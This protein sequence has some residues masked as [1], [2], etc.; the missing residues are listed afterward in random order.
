M[1]HKELIERLRSKGQWVRSPVG[2]P[3]P[4]PME[5][6]VPDEDC[7]AAAKALAELDKGA[8]SI[9]NYEE[10]LK[11]TRR[12]T[13]ELDVAMHGEDGAAQQASLCD[14][15][16]P[17]KRLRESK[18]ELVEALEMALAWAPY[19]NDHDGYLNRKID[20][21]RQVELVK[22]AITRHKEEGGG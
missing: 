16:E 1:A 17:A 20:I 6:F 11:D 7:Q 19:I 5:K 13:R 2:L 14:L 21:K 12:L 4:E 18:A 9:A 3:A 8:L 22:E 10:V 15:I